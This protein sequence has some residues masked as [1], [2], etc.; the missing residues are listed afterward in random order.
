MKLRYLTQR[1]S[2]TSNQVVEFAKQHRLG[3]TEAKRLLT[4][5]KGPT[6]QYWDED[7]NN[8]CDVEQVMEYVEK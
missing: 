7:S 1:R 4:K 2:I 6:L 3:L 5:Q 8:W